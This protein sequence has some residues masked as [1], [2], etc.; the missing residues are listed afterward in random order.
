MMK[1]LPQMRQRFH[2]FQVAISDGNSCFRFAGNGNIQLIQLLLFNR[3]G[4]PHHNILCALVHRERDNLP[5]AV[6][7]GK[8]H[9]HTV[10]AGCDTC[11]RRRTIFEGINQEAKLSHCTLWGK[12]ENLEHLLLKFTIMDT[13]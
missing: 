8:Q 13:E 11:M 4:G 2:I 3:G 7:A 10:D 5:N 9:N 6:L 1:A 12:A